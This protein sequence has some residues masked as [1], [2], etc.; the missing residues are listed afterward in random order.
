MGR[1][2][3]FHSRRTNYFKCRYWIRNESD[4]VGDASKYIY[5]NSPSGSFYAKPISAKSNQINVVSGVWALDSEHITLE[6]DDDI[7]EIRRG[8]IVE[9]NNEIWVVDSNQYNTH[10]KESEFCKHPDYKYIL[11]L[12][13]G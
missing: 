1:V 2:D 5:N 9:Y 10:L 7:T 12:S 13:K 4:L 3:L 6:T 8:C 11:S